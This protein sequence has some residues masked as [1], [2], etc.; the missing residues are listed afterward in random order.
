METIKDKLKSIIDTLDDN[1]LSK[2]S[3]NNIDKSNIDKTKEMSDFLFSMF[4][5]LIMKIVNKKQIS[6][7]NKDNQWIVQQDYKNSGLWIRYKLIWKV[8]EEKYSLKDQEIS[9]FIE[10]WVEA[11]LNWRG[12][13]PQHEIIK[14]V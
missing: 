5:G 3:E 13:T 14:L 4:N 6:Y 1:K 7:Y 12:L 9:N 2:L 8:F 11:N 10:G